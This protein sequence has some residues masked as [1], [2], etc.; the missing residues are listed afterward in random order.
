ATATA[1]TFQIARTDPAPNY[2]CYLGPSFKFVASSTNA[3]T[4]TLPKTRQILQRDGS[5]KTSIRLQGL[6]SGAAARL[7][8]RAVVM[9][10]S[11]NNGVSTDWFVIVNAPTN[12]S[13]AGVLPGVTAGGWYR[14]EVRAVDAATN[15]LATA[16]VDRVGVGDVFVTAGQ[17]NAACFGS[18][19]QRP[20]DDHVS[21]CILYTRYWQFA[22]DPQPDNSGGMGTGGSAWPILGS[23][24]VQSNHVPVGFIGVASGGT[25]LSQWV[26]GTSLFQNLTNALKAFG[27]NG[28][29]AVLWHQGESDSLAN[30]T[31]AGYA[32]QLSNIVATSR[33]AAGWSVPWG[34]AEASFHPSATR[35]QEEPV[36]AGQR[37]LTYTVANCFRGPRTDDFN[38]E[39]KLSDTVHFNTVGLTDH[40]QQW[41]NALYGVENLTPK[42]ANFEANTALADGATATSIRIIGW[43]RLNSTGTGLASGGNGYF[44]P[45]NSSYPDSA[46]TINGGV[47]PNMKGRYV[48]TLAATAT[49]NAFLQT[50]SAHLQPSTIYTFSVAVGVR[51]NTTV[52]GGYRLDLLANGTPLGAGTAGNLEALNALAG[53]SATGAFTV[54]S[55]VYTSAVAVPTNQQLGIRITKPSGT[56]TYLDFDNVQVTSQLTPYGEWQKLHW[57]SLT[58]PTSLPEADPDADGL[59]NLIE[60]QL[61]GMD[62]LVRDAMPLPTVMK[63]GGE[64]Y[65]QMQLLKNP[66]AATSGSVGL[67]MSYDLIVPFLWHKP[68][69]R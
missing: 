29:R 13:Y 47:L 35:A 20:S 11:T 67:L 40:A 38:L 6:S 50:L 30:T 48:G 36:A 65:L 63:L 14:V 43:N 51:T 5:N 18:P 25:A 39:G 69:W 22:A 23:L 16:G 46:D 34:I 66:A 44:N 41:A 62:P 2:A 8:A 57:G 37:L 4:L 7:E 12:G 45:N 31:A 28:V 21:A 1:T 9:P 61:L 54:V 32:Q 26:P 53:G 15:V 52:F 59:P 17:S 64:D 49:N 19:T 24:L 42:N 56:G 33:A 55:C 27:T 68:V 3:L 60:S 58:D 10:G